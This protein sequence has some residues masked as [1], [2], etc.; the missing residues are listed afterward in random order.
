MAKLRNASHL[1]V[2]LT[3]ALG[4]PNLSH[5][6]NITFAYALAPC[7]AGTSAA[8]I[9]SIHNSKVVVLHEEGFQ[10]HVPCQCGRRT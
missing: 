2:I 9:L 10:L 3:F 5:I 1:K 4:G 8:M 6:V 7:V